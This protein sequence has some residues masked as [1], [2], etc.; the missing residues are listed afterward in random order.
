MI[1]DS[2]GLKIKWRGYTSFNEPKIFPLREMIKVS[3]A[4]YLNEQLCYKDSL[5]S[6]HEL[7]T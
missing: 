3:K 4:T 5:G 7:Y 1:N 6:Y 2:P